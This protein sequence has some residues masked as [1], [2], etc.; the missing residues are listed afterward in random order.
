MGLPSPQLEGPR[1]SGGVH[2]PNS[3][4]L[5]CGEDCEPVILN[6][7]GS[8]T[9]PWEA[10]GRNEK[11]LPNHYRLEPILNWESSAPFVKEKEN[12][13]IKQEKKLCVGDQRDVE[14][15][16]MYAALVRLYSGMISK[17]ALQAPHRKCSL[18]VSVYVGRVKC[19]GRG[20]RVAGISHSCS[21]CHRR[22]HALKRGREG[23][24]GTISTCLHWQAST[25]LHWL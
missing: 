5:Q 22:V 16:C 13:A 21:F 14:N 1:L 19:V 18:W 17:T 10:A 23:G 20:V 6:S 11:W 9:N 7:T 8:L 2:P 12:A 15:V 4:D 3:R 24:G 25:P